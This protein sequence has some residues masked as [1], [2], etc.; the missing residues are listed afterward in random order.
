MGIRNKET[1]KTRGEIGLLG[2]KGGNKE[3][4]RKTKEE[5]KEGRKEKVFIGRKR[6]RRE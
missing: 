2:R 4:E 5:R 3:R 6:G 1:R